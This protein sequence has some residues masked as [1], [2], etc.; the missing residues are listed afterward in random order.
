MAEVLII[1]LLSSAVDSFKL[2]PL[3]VW[4]ASKSAFWEE[5]LKL[6]KHSLVVSGTSFISDSF[7]ALRL[8]QATPP[9]TNNCYLSL[10][11]SISTLNCQT[12]FGNIFTSSCYINIFHFDATR[13]K[14]L[15]KKKKNKTK[16]SA[17]PFESIWIS[18]MYQALF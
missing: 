11:P 17:H 1:G 14:V 12:F 6:S 10:L 16:N 9:F 3:N 18:I 2:H 15:Y 5:T 4:M 8:S 7:L 13:Y